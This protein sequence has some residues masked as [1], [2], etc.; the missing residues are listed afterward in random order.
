MPDKNWKTLSKKEVYDNP[1]INVSE[2]QGLNPNGGLVIYG[3]VHL[4]K[5]VLHICL[6]L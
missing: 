4:K 3:V 5:P 2:H 1:W 6:P